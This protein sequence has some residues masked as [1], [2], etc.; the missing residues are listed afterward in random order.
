[1]STKNATQPDLQVAYCDGQLYNNV[2]VENEMQIMWIRWLLFI[3]NQ[4]V[5][6]GCMSLSLLHYSVVFPLL[7]DSASGDGRELLLDQSQ[8]GEI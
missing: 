4:E 3:S 6:L 5:L 7:A 2:L 8:G 1:M